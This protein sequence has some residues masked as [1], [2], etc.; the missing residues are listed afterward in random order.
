MRDIKAFFSGK[1]II[2]YILSIISVISLTAAIILIIINVTLFN[3][4]NIKKYIANTDYIN[5][6]YNYIIENCKSQSNQYGYNESIVNESIK[7]EQVESDINE[8]IDA[9]CSDNEF[10]IDITECLIGVNEKIDAYAQENNFYESEETKERID[11]FKN[12]IQETYKK[13]ILYSDD[14]AQSAVDYS[15]LV[16]KYLRATIA[17]LLI[18]AIITLMLICWLNKATMGI[19]MLAVGV[20]LIVLRIYASLNVKVSDIFVFNDIFSKLCTTVINQVLQNMI[21]TGI[22]FIII[23]L[24]IIC[25][26]EKTKRYEKILLLDTHSHII[27]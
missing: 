18:I 2:S 7:I 6:A 19:S 13:G 10:N 15:R 14:T 24:I 5:N 16:I 1:K 9:I 25:I 4:K 12:K 11:E 26:V 27:Q 3:Q 8:F 21:V 23:G 22:V 20:S 17:L